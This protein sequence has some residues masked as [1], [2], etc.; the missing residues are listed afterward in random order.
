MVATQAS[1]RNANLYYTCELPADVAE[2]L[3]ISGRQ[4]PYPTRPDESVTREE[5]TAARQSSPGPAA[6]R[7]AF[8][9]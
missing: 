4:Q 5:S 7:S 2:V 9:W 3:L 6:T 1:P 8:Y